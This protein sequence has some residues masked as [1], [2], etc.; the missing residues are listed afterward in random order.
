[1]FKKGINMRNKLLLVFLSIML[2]A[3]IGTAISSIR[4]MVTPL[5]EIA[6]KDLESLV[7]EFY[8][9][10][11][12][13]PDM[14]W[15]VIKRICN[16]QIIVGETGFIFVV[17]SEGN[18]L[19]HKKSE[20]ENWGNKPHIKEILERKNGTLRYLS[21][22]TKT[23]KL[24]AFRYLEEWNWII[25]AGAFED[26]FLA[27]PRSEIIKYS[28]TAGG[29]IFILATVFI[30]IYVTKITRPITQ[31]VNMIKDVAQGEG[32]LTKRLD[33]NAKDE[34]GDLAK[35]FNIFMDKLHDII[36]TVAANTDKLASAA[37]EISSSAEELTVGVKE[38]NNQTTQVSTA[39]EEMAASIVENSK[40]TSEAAEKTKEVSNRAQEGGDVAEDTSRGMEEIV[41]SSQLTAQNIQGLAEK[42]TAIGE[43]IS[44]INDIADQTN[45]LAL[46]AAI[47]AARAGE[48]GRGFAVVA[49]E[50]RKLAERTTK[51]TTEVAETI[52]SIQSDVRNANEQINDSLKIVENGKNL[53]QKT[54]VSLNEIHS[55]IEIVQEMMKQ[56]TTASE[57]Q[58]VTAEQISKNVENV[59]RITKETATGTEQAAS[60]AEQLNRQVE[61]LRN[62]IGGFKTRK[63]VKAEV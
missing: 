32:D 53:V 8:T 25:V 37:N 20:G 36:A 49:D 61:E 39:V 3:V 42:A 28:A 17:D 54:N 10:A 47:E 27:K 58:S 23:Y 59:D 21:P 31:V 35:W 5:R 19:I 11:E 29:I 46:N 45:L 6:I 48:Q 40:N 62:L 51:A 13:N 60:T 7:D 4:G 30:F 12:A 38:Q 26:E 1:M 34:V 55:A 22:K 24:A 41:Q 33:I 15:A 63:E 9:F 2:V 16:E 50:V 44:V 56:V 57:E 14:E 52:K 43:I 18:L